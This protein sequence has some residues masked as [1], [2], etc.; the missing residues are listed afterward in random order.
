MHPIE[1]RIQRLYQRLAREHAQLLALW[2]AQ[3]SPRW[4]Q[5]SLAR[6]PQ[7]SPSASAAPTPEKERPR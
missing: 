5:A 1:K 3:S 4:G 2:K 7:E 6:R